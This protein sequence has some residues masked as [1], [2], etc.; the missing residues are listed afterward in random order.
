MM[1]QQKRLISF[2]TGTRRPHVQEGEQEGA[3]PQAPGSGAARHAD[4]RGP[5]HATDKAK[6]KNHNHTK[7]EQQ[8]QQEGE[9]APKAAEGRGEREAEDGE[10]RER[11]RGAERERGRAQ[12]KSAG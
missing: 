7:A 12:R 4:G 10:P 11:S 5:V 9:G 1:M 3:E 6:T 8:Q 2:R